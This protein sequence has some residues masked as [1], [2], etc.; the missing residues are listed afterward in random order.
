MYVEISLADSKKEQEKIEKTDTDRKETK[1]KQTERGE[2]EGCRE[3]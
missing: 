2:R 1:D 3:A